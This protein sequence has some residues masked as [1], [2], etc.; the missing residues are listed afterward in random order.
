MS[1]SIDSKLIEAV[2]KSPRRVL[3]HYAMKL[4]ITPEQSLQSID[5]LIQ[6]GQVQRHSHSEKLSIPGEVPDST[7]EAPAPQKAAKHPPKPQR[8]Q[9]TAKPAITQD[10]N[11]DGTGAP[12]DWLKLTDI[13]CLALKFLQASAEA[14]TTAQV[15]QAL[16]RSAQGTGS[17][18]NGLS[19]HGLAIRE[20]NAYNKQWR[21]T[22]DGRA[23]ALCIAPIAELSGRALTPPV[24]SYLEDLSLQKQPGSTI[25]SESTADFR[26]AYIP[27]TDEQMEEFRR[28]PCSFNAM[29]QAVHRAGFDSAPPLPIPTHWPDVF[30]KFEEL[31]ELLV[32]CADA[33]TTTTTN[34]TSNLNQSAT[35][36][37]QN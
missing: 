34:P 3:K 5:R 13:Q 11:E 18:L 7:P 15:A 4:G 2:K 31:F 22:K 28:I 16:N 8:T 21:I 35:T 33:T 17:A 36:G 25:D 9:T 6:S 10:Q 29:M 27:L 1:N 30:H 12:P 26:P 24:E 20:G 23:Q 14:M 37:E 19:R 32:L